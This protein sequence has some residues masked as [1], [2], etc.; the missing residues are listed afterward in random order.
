MTGARVGRWPLVPQNEEVEK[1]LVKKIAL[2]AVA[3]CWLCGTNAVLGVTHKSSKRKSKTSVHASLS[4]KQ[5]KSRTQQAGARHRW[6]YNPWQTSSHGDSAAGDDPA[7]EDPGIRS[8]ALAALGNWNGAVAVVDPNTGRILSLV[9]Q[10][11][12]T[13]GAFTPCSTIKPIT[14]LAALKEGLITPETMLRGERRLRVFGRRD[15]NLTTALAH[16]SNNYFSQVGLM[17]GFDRL[18]EYA[19][20]FG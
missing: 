15:I 11:L 16:S 3:L 14:A 9:N 5:L 10:K 4:R 1:T 7:G 20:R 19:R 2:L 6:R 12:A 8:A 17:L 13:E 18:S